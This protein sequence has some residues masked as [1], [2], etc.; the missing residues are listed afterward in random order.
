MIRTH[1]TFSALFTL[2]TFFT[3]VRSE[4]ALKFVGSSEGLVAE[5][6][7]AHE[8][9]FSAVREQMCLEVRSLGV[10]LATSWNMA[11]VF[12]LLGS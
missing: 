12:P 9:A 4:M 2:E 8:G 1:E 10:E 6:P 3:G 11:H 7:V 5:D